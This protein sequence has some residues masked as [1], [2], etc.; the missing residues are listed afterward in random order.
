MSEQVIK[1]WVTG[2]I[3]NT[4]EGGEEI[5]ISYDLGNTLE[6]TVTKYGEEVVHY[7]ACL[8]LATAIRNKLYALVQQEDGARTP[9]EV[10]VILT[11][12]AEWTPSVS[13]G[14]TKKSPAD[15][16]L[17]ALD[18]MTPEAKAE[19]LAELTASLSG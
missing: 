5:V 13:V 16:A 11:E 9:G 14:R 18:K 2:T 3:K 4:N 15:A 6:E 17:A 1:S 19:F 10:D 7:N 12:M 8:R